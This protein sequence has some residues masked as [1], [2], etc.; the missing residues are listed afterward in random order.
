MGGGVCGG[1]GG[2]LMHE[3]TGSQSQQQVEEGRGI[4]AVRDGGYRGEGRR[5]G[6]EKGRHRRS[7]SFWASR[8][9]VLQV[10]PCLALKVGPHVPEPRRGL[11]AAGRA[12]AQAAMPSAC[13]SHLLARDLGAR[14]PANLLG[15]LVCSWKRNTLCSFTQPPRNVTAAARA[16]RNQSPRGPPRVPSAQHRAQE[17]A[18]LRPLSCGQSPGEPRPLGT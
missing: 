4:N 2:L 11:P 17:K 10:L 9:F 3:K 5:R 13:R 6:T 7:E 15:G 14:S 8:G 1:E 12:A 16:Q 18:P